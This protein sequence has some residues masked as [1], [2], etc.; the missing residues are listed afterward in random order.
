MIL[1]YVAFVVEVELENDS[2][3]GLAQIVDCKKWP[4]DVGDS[5]SEELWIIVVA[6][7]ELALPF[8]RDLL[9]ACISVQAA[10]EGVS[11]DWVIWTGFPW[12]HCCCSTRVYPEADPSASLRFSRSGLSAS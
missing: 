12:Y 3:I 11:A 8:I 6:C 5:R 7:N 1:D 4:D 2:V 9:S 10:S